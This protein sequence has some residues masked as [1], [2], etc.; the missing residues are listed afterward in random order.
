MP[1][2]D[3][4]SELEGSE[5][6]ATLQTNREFDSRMKSIKNF[7]E[8]HNFLKILVISSKKLVVRNRLASTTDEIDTG[9]VR[10]LEALSPST[11]YSLL[12]QSLIKQLCSFI[13]RDR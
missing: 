13:E 5:R 9:K 4:D 11:P 8:F 1:Q 3:S 2:S 7:R 12:V 10:Y 6:W